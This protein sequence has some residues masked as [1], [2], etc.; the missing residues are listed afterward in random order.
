MTKNEFD[1]IMWSVAEINEDRIFG[2]SMAETY[3]KSIRLAYEI[4]IKGE[5][6]P[7]VLYNAL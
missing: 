5:T 1:T 7:Q 4:L 3:S 6:D 2:G